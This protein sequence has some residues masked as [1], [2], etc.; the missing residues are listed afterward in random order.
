MNLI[1]CQYI[2]KFEVNLRRFMQFYLFASNILFMLNRAKMKEIFTAIICKLN[3]PNGGL[4]EFL[5][6]EHHSFDFQSLKLF[7]RWN[8]NHK[9]YSSRKYF[10]R[11]PQIDLNVTFALALIVQGFYWPLKALLSKLNN[12]KT[13]ANRMAFI[14]CLS[15]NEQ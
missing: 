13:E 5:Y 9:K 1:L 7:T 12:Y 11:L 4:N 15:L 8:H 2:S 3:N 14:R 6:S 10:I